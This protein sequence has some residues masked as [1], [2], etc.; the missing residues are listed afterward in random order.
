MTATPDRNFA[1][2]PSAG[3]EMAV[4]AFAPMP[5]GDWAEPE[6]GRGSHP[7]AMARAR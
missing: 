5:E 4:E 1:Q 2:L 3:P 6:R 7:R